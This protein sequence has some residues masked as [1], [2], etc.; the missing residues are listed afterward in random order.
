MN[1]L[2]SS[3]SELNSAQTP[4][5]DAMTSSILNKTKHLHE[6][7]AVYENC[8]GLVSHKA[9]DLQL[10]HSKIAQSR[11]SLDNM[12]ATVDNV[13]LALDLDSKVSQLDALKV[14][15]K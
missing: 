7:T 3:L 5:S 4:Q 1:E 13:Q 14:G 15:Y 12:A 10:V 2:L 9:Q 8:K 6:M 11:S